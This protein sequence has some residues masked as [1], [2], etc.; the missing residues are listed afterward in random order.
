MG[1]CVRVNPDF[2]RFSLQQ[3]VFDT[4]L[5]KKIGNAIPTAAVKQSAKVLGPLVFT[6]Y[7]IMN[8]WPTTKHL[9]YHGLTGKFPTLGESPVTLSIRITWTNQ[10]SDLWVIICKCDWPIASVDH[11]TSLPGK[12]P[13]TVIFGNGW[14]NMLEVSEINGVAIIVV[15]WGIRNFLTNF[16]GL[17][18]GLGGLCLRVRPTVGSIQ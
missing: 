9:L 15:F 2:N 13:V 6:Y 17:R 1:Y 8:F 18:K 16:S 4:S 11:I 3:W 12:F 14:L 10:H 7:R 5:Q